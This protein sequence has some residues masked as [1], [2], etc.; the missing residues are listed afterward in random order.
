MFRVLYVYRALYCYSFALV[1]SYLKNHSLILSISKQKQQTL[2]ISPHKHMHGHMH[3]QCGNGGSSSISNNN[4]NRY[5]CSSARL[6]TH[7]QLR[8][9][10][11]SAVLIFTFSSF[12]I[13]SNIQ[14]FFACIRLCLS[15][16][17]YLFGCVYVYMSGKDDTIEV[18][19]EKC[20]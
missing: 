8:L 7:S 10:L 12:R 18:I 9:Q 15:L 11:K 17:V 4:N 6:P 3:T 13:P 20:I 16:F 5:G 1:L 19:Y 14:V 2:H